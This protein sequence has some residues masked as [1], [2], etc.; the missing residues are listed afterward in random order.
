MKK[1]STALAICGL[2][3][4]VNVAS[5]QISGRVGDD[6]F[7]IVNATPAVNASG[8]DLN[9]PGGYLIPVPPGDLTAPAAPFAFMLANN[10]KQVTFGNLGTSVAI[11]GDLVTPVGYDS[12][13][14]NA[15]GGTDITASL[16]ISGSAVGMPF[17]V[18]AAGG[19]PVDPGPTTP[20][21]ATGLLAIFGALGLLGFRRRR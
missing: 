12:A 14:N 1:F 16:G 18:A 21:P 11:D 17:S 7:I 9:S 6:G 3:L 5:A 4:A 19:G 15:D 8:L 13:G 2:I 10:N 20:E